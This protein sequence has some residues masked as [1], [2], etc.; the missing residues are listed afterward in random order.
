[1]NTK[2]QFIVISGIDGSG[3]T[4]QENLLVAN[5]RKLGKEVLVTKNPTD[6]YRQIPA[7]RQFIDTGDQTLRPETMAL[8]AAADRMNQLDTEIIPALEK[9][10]DVVCNRYVD[11]T[12][13]YFKARGADLD[14]VEAINGKILKPDKGIFLKID[15]AESVKRIRIRN[16]EGEK[17]EEK[18]PLYLKAV[19]EEMLR[20]WSDDFLVLD[21]TLSSEKLS[22]EVFEYVVR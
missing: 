17:Y 18:N 10:F 21:A 9:G 20:W 22:S 1:M 7:V 3:K 13:G 11:S 5:L 2:G 4:T 8:F 6:W 19:Q 14:F 12:F 15:P 16:P